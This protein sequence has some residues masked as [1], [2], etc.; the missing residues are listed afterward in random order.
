M[1]IAQITDTHLYATPDG[2]LLGLNTR[3]CLEQVLRLVRKDTTFDLVVASGDLAHDGSMSAY[4][5]LREQVGQ[6]GIPA[7]CLPGNHDEAGAIREY[8]DAGGFHCVRSHLA[9]GWQQVFLDSTVE[10]EDGGHLAEGELDALSQALNAH[11]GL[12][13]LVW[14]H[15]QPVLMGS[16]WLDTMAVDNP[17]DFFAVIDRHSQVRAIAW[18]HVHQAFDQ[19]RNDVRLLS[20]PSTCLQFLPASEDFAVDEIPPGYRW[21]E[22]HPDGKLQTGITRL[23]HIPGHIDLA[24]SGY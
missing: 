8:L 18:G 22:L 20:S 3:D 6:L 21:L 10:G 9:G 23:E 13:T 17:D 14:L 12:P 11:P 2:R 1:R 4:L 24:A 5:G 7:Y 19:R 16:R 15:H